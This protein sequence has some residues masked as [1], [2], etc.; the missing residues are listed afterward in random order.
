M[1][2]SANPIILAVACH[3]V[4]QYVKYNAKGG[5]SALESTGAKQ[6]VMELMTHEDADV[7]FHALSA[8]QKYFAMN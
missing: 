7:R 2:A 8:T 6:R 1:S 5:K 4:G 3:D